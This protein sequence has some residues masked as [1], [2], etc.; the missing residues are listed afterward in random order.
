MLKMLCASALLSGFLTGGFQDRPY[1]LVK[2]Q[3]EES[4]NEEYLPA[5]DPPPPPVAIITQCRLKRDLSGVA[6]SQD[7]RSSIF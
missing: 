6:L 2:L 7:R 4:R 3:G 5:Q 1:T